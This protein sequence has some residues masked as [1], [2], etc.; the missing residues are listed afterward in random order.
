M[1]AKHSW[2][3]RNT[4]NFSSRETPQI[5]SP[6]VPA[7]FSGICKLI[8]NPLRS[9]SPMIVDASLMPVKDKRAKQCSGFQTEVADDRGHVYYIPVLTHLAVLTRN[10]STTRNAMGLPVGGAP[11]NSPL[12]VP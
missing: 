10:R 7:K 11:R 12:C 6:S 8:F 3:W 4:T 5:G 1:L 2:T 9:E